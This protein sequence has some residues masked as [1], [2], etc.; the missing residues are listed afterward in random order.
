MMD[1]SSAEGGGGGGGGGGEEEEEEE[2]WLVS[3]IGAGVE[4]ENGR[5]VF[6]INEQ[7]HS[8]LW[9]RF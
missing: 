6:Q 9:S 8:K 1:W 2:G 7:S 4:E 5:L 3:W